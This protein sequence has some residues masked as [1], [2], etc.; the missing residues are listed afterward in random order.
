[1]YEQGFLPPSSSVGFVLP[2]TYE[3][4]YLSSSLEHSSQYVVLRRDSQL[5]GVS[6]MEALESARLCYFPAQSTL[7]YTTLCC[8]DPGR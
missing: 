2:G 7:V 5:G 4:T 8:P 1:M 3:G 6:T